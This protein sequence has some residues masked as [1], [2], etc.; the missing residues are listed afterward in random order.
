MLIN[1]DTLLLQLPNFEFCSQFEDFKALKTKLGSPYYMAPEV[2]SK[3][4]GKECDLWSIGAMTYF[5]LTGFPPFLGDTPTLFHE[6][7]EYFKLNL[8]S[9]DWE[10]KSVE[11][12]AFIRKSLTVDPRYRITIK[13]ALTHPWINEEHKVETLPNPQEI[14][15]DFD[16]R[17]FDIF[18]REVFAILLENFDLGSLISLKQL[19]DSE[20]SEIAKEILVNDILNIVENTEAYDLDIKELLR[21]GLKQLNHH[22]DC[23]QFL[24]AVIEEK[25]HLEQP[26]F[27]LD[28]I[29]PSSGS[30]TEDS[31]SLDADK[32]SP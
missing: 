10:G 19:T 25:R 26:R 18:L 30:N 13:E 22:V 11:A 8:V 4:Y 15:I 31:T 5:M 21:Y 7:L 12:L 20:N 27:D 17:T 14:G 28:F 32:P 6:Q 29:F 1:P 9:E 24:E 2:L 3:S 23:S 16:D